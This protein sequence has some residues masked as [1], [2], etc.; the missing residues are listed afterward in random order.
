MYGYTV[1]IKYVLH[2]Y[3]RSPNH[4]PTHTH[5]TPTHTPIHMITHTQTHTH[6]HTH[7][8]TQSQ[9][10]NSV[11]V[12]GHVGPNQR[13]PIRGRSTIH[14][15]QLKPKEGYLEKLTKDGKRWNKRYFELE[16]SSLHYYEGKGQKY[17]DTIKMYC[18]PVKQSP[19]DRKVLLI[20]TGKRV[21][22]LRAENESV[23]DEWLQALMMHSQGTAR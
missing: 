8:H 23:A 6:T 14:R 13:L 2:P 11:N 5:I 21:W 20:E 3:T 16:S 1:H 22:S 7:T 17:G 9:I 18:V 10:P 15:N 12:V 19:T 4:P